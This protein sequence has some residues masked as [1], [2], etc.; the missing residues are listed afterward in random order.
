MHNTNKIYAVKSF[1]AIYAVGNKFKM[2]DGN[3]Y[4]I[5]RIAISENDRLMYGEYTYH[6]V[7]DINGE[8]ILWQKI[9]F[10]LGVLVNDISD[11]L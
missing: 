8:E 7:L 4:K 5:K 6:V 10:S 1:G 2:V 11:F 9:P 3:Y